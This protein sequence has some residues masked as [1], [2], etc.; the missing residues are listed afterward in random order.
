MSSTLP[1]SSRLLLLRVDR[2]T[3]SSATRPIPR[4]SRLVSHPL[5][6][7][8]TPKANRLS[9]LPSRYL[10]QQQQQQQ[11]ATGVVTPCCCHPRTSLYSSS[12]SLSS[13]SSS[14]SSCSSSTPTFHPLRSYSSATPSSNYVLPANSHHSS[15]AHSHL[16]LL[17]TVSRPGSIHSSF[18]RVVSLP[19]STRSLHTSRPLNTSKPTTHTSTST[20]TNTMAKVIDGKAI[21]QNLRNDIKSQIEEMRKTVP[22]FNPKLSIIQVGAR[23]DSSVYVNMKKKAAKEVIMSQRALYCVSFRG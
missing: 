16:P 14:L 9:T 13:S 23:E 19:T 20:T 7:T 8:T 11:A 4:F 12:F 3:F 18:L 17:T 2:T 5:R 10:L 21:A 22:H 6:S 1:S 15:P